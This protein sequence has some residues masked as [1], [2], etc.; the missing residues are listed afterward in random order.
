M[1]RIFIYNRI[2]KT[3][4]CPAVR[5]TPKIFLLITIKSILGLPRRTSPAEWAFGSSYANLLFVK[6][7]IVQC[8]FNLFM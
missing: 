7:D 6:F 3:P 5:S 8:G 4:L 2:L 1:E